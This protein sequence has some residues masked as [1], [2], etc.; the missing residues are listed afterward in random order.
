MVEVPASM[1]PTVRGRLVPIYGGPLDQ[2]YIFVQ[3]KYPPIRF[4]IHND[5][6]E[7][8]T[9]VLEQDEINNPLYR[10]AQ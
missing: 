9:Y 3:I 5:H 6:E 2:S 8:L 7:E 10:L 1:N 4:V